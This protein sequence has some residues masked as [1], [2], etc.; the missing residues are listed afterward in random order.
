[1]GL[2]TGSGFSNAPK[3]RSAPRPPAQR[4]R[5][6]QAERDG[7]YEL[8]PCSEGRRRPDLLLG[9]LRYSL[10]SLRSAMERV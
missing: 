2:N 5:P 10:R 3:A 8:A 7:D 4:T 6:D 9:R 1:V